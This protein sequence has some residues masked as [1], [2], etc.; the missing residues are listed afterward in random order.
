MPVRGPH[1]QVLYSAHEAYDAMGRRRFEHEWT[2]RFTGNPPIPDLSRMRTLDERGIE[3]SAEVRGFLRADDPEGAEGAQVQRR[4]EDEIMKDLVNALEWG[5]AECLTREPDW[6]SVP[7]DEWLEGTD[8]RPFLL[9]LLREDIGIVLRDGGVAPNRVLIDKR[10]FDEWLKWH[11]SP[12]KCSPL[13]PPKPQPAHRPAAD[14]DCIRGEF[15]RRCEFGLVDVGRK[16]WRT[17]EAAHLEAW[18]KNVRPDAVKANRAPNRDT[19]RR[20]LKEDFDMYEAQ[21]AS[22]RTTG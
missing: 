12:Q 5:K 9:K 7:P 14:W 3:L 21:S 10:G 13:V 19:I 16:G 2:S 8:T 15:R 17:H 18:F 22:G 4:R 1:G 11:G 6:R 20:H